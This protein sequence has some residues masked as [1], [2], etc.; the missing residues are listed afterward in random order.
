MDFQQAAMIEF[1]SAVTYSDDLLACGHSVH[2]LCS[3]QFDESI[4]SKTAQLTWR[5]DDAFESTSIDQS[6][7]FEKYH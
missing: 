3:V 2:R 7:I 5:Y 4:D 1:V 6:A